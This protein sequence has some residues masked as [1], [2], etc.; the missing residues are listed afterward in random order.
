MWQ[1][2]YILAKH[3]GCTETTNSSTTT[4]AST[5]EYTIPTGVLNI[6][7]VTWYNFPLEKIDKNELDVYEGAAYNFSGTSGQPIYYYEYGAYIGLS[8]IPNAA[9]TLKLWYV[10]E[11]TE[12]TA[13]S[14]AFTI[15]N[16]F[17]FYLPDY[18]LYRMYLKDDNAQLAEVHKRLWDENLDKAL[19]E[20]K[21]RSRSNRRV[22]VKDSELIPNARLR[23]A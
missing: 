12:L 4:V 11:P 18:C 1:G 20:W 21:A 16:D 14:T 22:I 8:P 7:R 3:T 6:T 13:A 2:E 23:I 15:P 19:T 9:Q 17:A 5:R 10:A